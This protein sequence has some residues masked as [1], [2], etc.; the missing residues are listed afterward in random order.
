MKENYF[1]INDVNVDALHNKS[2]D[3]EDM[4]TT[5]IP[6]INMDSKILRSAV[7]LPGDRVSVHLDLSVEDFAVLHLILTPF[8]KFSI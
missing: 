2:L 1:K 6:V 4:S 3:G 8:E 7:L 5:M